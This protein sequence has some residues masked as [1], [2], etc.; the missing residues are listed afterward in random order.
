M[1]SETAVAADDGDIDGTPTVSFCAMIRFLKI[2]SVTRSR[3]FGQFVAA[4]DLHH[5][6]DRV[7]ERM[8]LVF[9]II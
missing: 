4:R 7:D 2:L 9:A 1:S 6:Q 8:L 5:P 3:R